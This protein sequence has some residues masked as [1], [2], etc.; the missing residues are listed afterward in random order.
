M[1]RINHGQ[2]NPVTFSIDPVNPD[3]KDVADGY[4]FAGVGDPALHHLGNMDQAILVQADID[5]SAEI[6]DVANDTFQLIARM[7]IFQREDVMP[8]HWS[9]KL[10]TVIA[11]WLGNR[12]NHVLQRIYV[13][14]QLFCGFFQI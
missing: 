13:R 2:L 1:M 6:N 14:V 4:N 11:Q 7:Q 5:E 12:F 3:L 10:F 9:V 8:Q